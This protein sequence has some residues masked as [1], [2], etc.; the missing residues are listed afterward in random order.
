MK[1]FMIFHY[2]QKEVHGLVEKWLQGLPGVL[3]QLKDDSPGMTEL[4]L[5]DMKK[6]LVQCA[7]QPDDN[8]L[9]HLSLFFGKCSDIMQPEFQPTSLVT[10]SQERCFNQIAANGDNNWLKFRQDTTNGIFK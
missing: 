7:L 8:F 6:A 2:R 4:V 3:V 10:N 5:K 1:Q 9:A